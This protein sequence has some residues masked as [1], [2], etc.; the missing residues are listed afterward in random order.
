[1]NNISEGEVFFISPLIYI[2]IFK[3]STGPWLR[4]ATYFSM[5]EILQ[6]CL[7]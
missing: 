3:T 1:M 6:D 4:L 2:S 7:F 5:D